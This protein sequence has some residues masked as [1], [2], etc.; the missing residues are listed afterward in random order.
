MPLGL[1]G[2]TCTMTDEV[3]VERGGRQVARYYVRSCPPVPAQEEE[4]ASRD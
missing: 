1:E 2:R 3:D 4:R